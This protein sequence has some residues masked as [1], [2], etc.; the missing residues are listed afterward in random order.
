MIRLLTFCTLA[1]AV[2][3]TV[4][5]PA[6]A[7]KPSDS[8]L[9]ISV[10]DHVVEGQWDIALR[11]LDH[12]IGLDGNDDGSITWG[13]LR[14]RQD[15]IASYAISRLR[16]ERGDRPCGLVPAAHLVDDHSDGTYA[17]LHFVAHCAAGRESPL[18]IGYSLF[19]DLD[20]QHRGLLRLDQRN[21]GFTA[22][23]SPSAPTVRVDAGA[24]SVSRQFVHFLEEGV[25]HIWIGFDHILF[26]LTLLLPSVLSRA[27]GRWQPVSG[28]RQAFLQVLKV[29][30]AFTV[31]HS[32]TLSLAV[33]GVI[34]PPARLV[35]S[36]IAFSVLIAA[37]NNV[38]PI[39]TRRLWCV[40]LGFGL[41]HGFGFANVLID[42][43]LP[44]AALALAL[45]GF[46]LGVELGQL[47]IVMAFLPLAFAIRRTWSYRGWVMPT[48]S[49]AVAGIATLWLV[50]RSLDLDVPWV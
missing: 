22:I 21:R 5:T 35:E 28:M 32:I 18:A 25:W 20:P 12:A 3:S 43:G 23:F 10:R 14:A 11:D 8:Y 15:A 45:F 38:V 7:H 24:A 48:A 19:F 13:E 50:E 36:L 16:L 49:L 37:A 26:L 33:L 9:K 39:V 2:L 1:L 42:L 27:D 40:A 47:A 41:I 44:K 46:N 29:V 6:R 31:A 34:A 4:A 30:T 17:V